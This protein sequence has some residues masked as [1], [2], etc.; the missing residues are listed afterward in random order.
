MREHRPWDRRCNRSSTKR[1]A[2]LSAGDG[3]IV[4]EAVADIIGERHL[5]YDD[6]LGSTRR[7]I[8]PIKASNNQAK[9]TA[10]EIEIWLPHA[11]ALRPTQQCAATARRSVNGHEAGAREHYLLYIAETT[12][13]FHIN[14]RHQ[15]LPSLSN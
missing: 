14:E 1:S 3:N 8:R 10:I 5:F 12:F 6:S 15:W 11:A 9:L 2:L 7:E 13:A 4:G